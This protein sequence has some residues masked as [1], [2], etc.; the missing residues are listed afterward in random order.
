MKI[1]VTGAS[2]GVGRTLAEELHALGHDVIGL[3]RTQQDAQRL[4][5]A[6]GHSV[7]LRPVVGDV[8]QRDSLDAAV[9]G[10]E[11][12]VHAAGR[13]GEARS[14]EDEKDFYDTNVG[15]TGNLWRAAGAA[16]VHEAVLIST[17]AVHD[18]P[19]VPELSEDAPLPNPQGAY[20]RT[21]LAA[22]RVATLLGSIHGMATVILRPAVVY[23]PH[24]TQFLPRILGALQRRDFAFVGDPDRPMYVCA[25]EH[26]TQCANHALRIPEAAG[27]AFNVMDAE[28]PTWHQF[29]TLVCQQAGL[30]V[31]KRKVSVETAVR[32]G[33]LMD[34]LR[35]RGLPAPIP[36]LSRHSAVV[37]GNR[38]IYR[39]D[40]ARSILGYQPVQSLVRAAPLLVKACLD[41]QVGKE[42][43]TA[44]SD[45]GTR[46]LGGLGC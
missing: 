42:S 46:L 22:E 32:A 14:A 16:G 26:I 3:V 8:K 21:K 38:C 20:E 29:I 41:R 4:M 5:D 23:G 31:P 35:A 18:H 27:E 39:I 7:S 33:R 19:N 28:L 6:W 36:A 15:G 2:R 12:V 40:K 1:L 11:A 30:R 24:D 25:A 13:V 43:T 45:E 37:L 10:R 9:R 17:V 34:A 44:L